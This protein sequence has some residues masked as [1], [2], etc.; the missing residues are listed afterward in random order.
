MNI[1]VKLTAKDK[2]VIKVKFSNIGM[3]LCN[4]LTIEA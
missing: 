4:S 1:G 3:V 2:Y